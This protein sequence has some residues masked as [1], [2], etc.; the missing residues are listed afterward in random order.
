MRR[1][2]SHVAAVLLGDRV[3]LEEMFKHR[4]VQSCPKLTGVGFSVGRKLHQEPCG[5]DCGSITDRHMVVGAK[6]VQDLS[7]DGDLP[8]FDTHDLVSFDECFVRVR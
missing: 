5:C 4:F 1:S 2:L 8:K 6:I 7:H 3:S